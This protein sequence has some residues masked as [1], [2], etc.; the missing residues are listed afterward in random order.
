MSKPA[1]SLWVFSLYMFALG[2]ALV[3]APN[4]PL[5]LFGVPET[6]EVWIRV[7]GMLVFIIGYLDFMAARHELHIFFAWTVPPRL[8]VPVFLTS[9]VML[10]WAPPVLILFG[11]ID[12]A[13]ALWTATT[14][15][16]EKSISIAR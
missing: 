6:Q 13:G 12:G 9:F 1:F 15:R 5:S 16:S 2:T 3:A 10:G 11:A 7:V 14:L 4:V 8:L